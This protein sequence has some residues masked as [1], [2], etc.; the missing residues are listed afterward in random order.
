MERRRGA[1]SLET[2]PKMDGL[3]SRGVLGLTSEAVSAALGAS[4]RK[5]P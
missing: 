3:G 4:S 5:R 1:V 2:V